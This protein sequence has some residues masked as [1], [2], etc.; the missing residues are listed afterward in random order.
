MLVEPRLP[1]GF[2]RPEET[3][4]SCA[5]VRRGDTEAVYGACNAL[6]RRTLSKFEVAEVA[7]LPPLISS[8]RNGTEKEGK[9]S[10]M[11]QTMYCI[12]PRI[13]NDLKNFECVS[14]FVVK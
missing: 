5:R 13:N 9:A 14:F 2:Q 1:R 10:R 7:L 8:G 6:N 4:R 3:A 12:F 11:M